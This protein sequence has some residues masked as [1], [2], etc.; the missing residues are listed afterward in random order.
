M[1]KRPLV[2]FIEDAW[3]GVSGVDSLSG[4]IVDIFTRYFLTLLITIL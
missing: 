2:V 4:R 1:S 3:M